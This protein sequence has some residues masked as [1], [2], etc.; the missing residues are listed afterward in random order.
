[1]RLRASLLT[2]ILAVA[3]PVAGPADP[4]GADAPASLEGAVSARIDNV[5]A[6]ILF[7]GGKKS[8]VPL[9]ALSAA[10][11]AWLEKFASEHPLSHGNS[12]VTIAAAEATAK[13]VKQ[14]I[15]RSTVEGALETVQLCPPAVFR[16]Q[17]G[18]TC[19][20]YAIV[21]AMDIAGFY[22]QLPEVYKIVNMTEATSPKNPWAD[23]RYAPALFMFPRKYAPRSAI[24]YPDGIRDPFDWARDELRR[25]HPILAAFPESIWEGLPPQFVAAHAWD[26]GKEG[27]A[28]V[29]N[30]FTWNKA[31][32]Q[33]TFHIINSWKDLS[34]FDLTV[35][36]A[37]GLL[38]MQ[39]S[40][41]AKNEVEPVATK[42]VV[43][44]VLLVRSAGNVN[45]YDVETNM[46]SHNVAAPNEAEAKRLVESA[47]ER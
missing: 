36:A 26:G 42:E 8:L 28:I 41:S 39:W 23:P 34:E 45:L 18:N 13:P 40:L 4:G 10:D 24:H 11:R 12:T 37:K 47:G 38:V 29:V 27:H 6:V 1:M 25:G 16:D 44:K 32:G 43:T 21:H 17:I 35:E 20:L 33:G 3:P 9:T 5:Y 30:G 14:T 22:V 19:Q 7:S 31:T 2:A 15:V 46:G